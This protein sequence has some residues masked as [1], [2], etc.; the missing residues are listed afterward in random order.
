MLIESIV[1]SWWLLRSWQFWWDSGLC[2]PVVW[3]RIKSRSSLSL[4]FIIL[5]F[6]ALYLILVLLRDRIEAFAY[7]VVCLNQF[8]ILLEHMINH[9]PFICSYILLFWRQDFGIESPIGKF[10]RLILISWAL[11]INSI[12]ILQPQASNRFQRSLI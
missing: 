2:W 1:C 11:L 3:G 9:H 8:Q 12:L 5:V 7:H 4:I 6:T 10:G